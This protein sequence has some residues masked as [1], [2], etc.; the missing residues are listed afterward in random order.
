LRHLTQPHASNPTAQRNTHHDNRPRNALDRNRVAD[1]LSRDLFD[2]RL[3]RAASDDR[4]R[5]RACE[6]ESQ[7]IQHERKPATVNASGF[8][9]SCVADVNGWRNVA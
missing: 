7:S 9:D 1:R 4:K 6:A 8:L 2:F 5:R 3:D